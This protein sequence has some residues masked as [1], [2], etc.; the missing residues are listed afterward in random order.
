MTEL[1][2]N[3]GRVYLDYLKKNMDLDTCIRKLEALLNSETIRDSK[4]RISILRAYDLLADDN[5]SK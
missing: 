3:P 1:D 5:D 4:K 2:L